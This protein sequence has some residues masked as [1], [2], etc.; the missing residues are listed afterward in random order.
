MTKDE[1]AML[2][3]KDG[4]TAEDH[5]RHG[6]EDT[7]TAAALNA[8]HELEEMNAVRHMQTIRNHLDMSFDRIMYGCNCYK[9]VDER[10]Q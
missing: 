10:R 4:R 6:C 5:A 2:G 8:I 7:V 9:T 1:L 3:V